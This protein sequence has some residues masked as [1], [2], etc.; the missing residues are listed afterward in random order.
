MTEKVGKVLVTEETV[1]V[2]LRWCG[3]Q[4]EELRTDGEGG[5]C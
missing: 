4:I 5:I 2:G 3:M 1:K